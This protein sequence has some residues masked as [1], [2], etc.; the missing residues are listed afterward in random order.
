MPIQA[1]IDLIMIMTSISLV[2]TPRSMHA[3]AHQCP[4]RAGPRG[5]LRCRFIPSSTIKHLIPAPRSFNSLIYPIYPIPIMPT[6]KLLTFSDYAAEITKHAKI[7]DAYIEE[8]DLPQPSF[9]QNGPLKFPVP[10]SALAAQASRTA[11]VEASKSLFS[12]A[13]GPTNAIAWPSLTRQFD[14]LTFRAIVEFDIPASVPLN[15]TASF[16]S[17]SVKTG[18]PEEAVARIIRH[19]ATSHI[20]HEVRAG[21]VEHTAMSRVLLENL[22]IRDYIRLFNNEGLTSSLKFNDAVRQYSEFGPG[23][24]PF[25]LAFSTSGTYY[26]FIQRPEEAKRLEAFHGCMR[27]MVRDAEQGG[28]VQN[29]EALLEY[30]DWESKGDGLVVDVSD[31]L[32]ILCGSGA[33]IY[34]R[35]AV[36]MEK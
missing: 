1:G 9:S 16:A 35:S 22:G 7:L 11:I 30:F 24:T 19:A 34:N 21:W 15:G 13:A 26:D 32:Q 33:D 5:P 36:P 20:F 8:N 25:G 17:I 29:P 10:N 6:T 31:I 4:V 3:Q 23:K 18:L 12:L 2:L 28:L 27:Y 14:L